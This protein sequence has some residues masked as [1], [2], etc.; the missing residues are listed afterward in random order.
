[1]LL[2]E[3]KSF[4]REYRGGFWATRWHSLFTYTAILGN[5]L[6]TS[7]FLNNRVK[8]QPSTVTEDLVNLSNN[9]Q[10]LPYMVP[11]TITICSSPELRLFA[12]LASADVTGPWLR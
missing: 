8:L 12:I 5:R 2:A 11:A 4:F 3:T 1:M 10:S 9:Y 7:L 6:N